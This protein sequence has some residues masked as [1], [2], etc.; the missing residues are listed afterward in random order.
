MKKLL[1]LVLML[2]VPLAFGADQ[3]FKDFVPAQPAAASQTGAELLP[4]V[5]SAA[6]AQVT[7]SQIATYT[8]GTLTSSGITGK[9][10]GTCD[11][12]HFLR[13]DGSCSLINLSSNVSSI[14]PVANGGSGVATLTGI[15]KG[16]GTSAFSAATSSDVIGLWTGT[17][18][19]GAS[20]RGDGSCQPS[21]TG[22]VTSVALTVP[23]WLS[24]AGSPV[25]SS[26]TLAVTATTGQTANQFLA[27]PN[28]ST[29]TVGLRA[30]VAADLPSIDLT[31][32]VTN[33]LPA[34]NG[35]TSNGFAAFSGPAT[36]TKTFT[37]PNASASIL[38]D[39]ASVTVAQGGTGTNTLTNHGVLLGQGT[40][41][42]TAVAAMAADTLLQ[43]QGATSNPAAVSVNNCGDSTHALS[44]NTSTHAFGC[45]AISAGGGSTFTLVKKTADTSRSST[46][47]PT[48]DPDL[49]F[50]S[51]AAGQYTI[52]CTIYAT[53]AT[54]SQSLKFGMSGGGTITAAEW[55]A[56]GADNGNNCGNGVASTFGSFTS[57][58]SCPS[59]SS[60]SVFIVDSVINQSTSGTITFNWAQNLSSGTNLTVKAGSAC[61]LY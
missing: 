47:S 33:I 14:L 23:S 1:S 59:N 19:A 49:Q 12:S 41:A 15:A 34:A 8:L 61:M 36:S 32:K 35:G 11:L 28:G 2:A 39:N 26:G 53:S 45:Q 6:T 20:L 42:V 27:T 52:H 5:Q 17:C 40:S 37:L 44:Y 58:G 38:T 57:M 51:V 50:A 21:A 43:G 10:S 30:I 60:N 48:A 55:G 13:G 9:F 24:V 16:S 31:T 7:T 46:T 29:G 22:S 4:E 25:T 56:Q 54:A 18:N 3:K